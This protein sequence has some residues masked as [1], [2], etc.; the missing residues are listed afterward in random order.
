MMISGVNWQRAGNI[1]GLNLTYL[2]RTVIQ[3][4]KPSKCALNEIKSFIFC[5][6][7]DTV[8]YLKLDV[9]GNFTNDHRGASKEQVTL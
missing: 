3:N 9:K 2:E 8:I 6:R 5:F 4:W 7:L 1:Q